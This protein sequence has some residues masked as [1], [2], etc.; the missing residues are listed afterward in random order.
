MIISPVDTGRLELPSLAAYASEAYAYTNSAT[1][2]YL[3]PYQM[4]GFYA[5]FPSCHL[6]TVTSSG[7]PRKIEE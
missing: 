6:Y 5:F 3:V 7:E 1:C 4:L 2:P